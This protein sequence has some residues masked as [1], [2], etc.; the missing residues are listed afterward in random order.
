MQ[1]FNK[2]PGN[3]ESQ[4]GGGLKPFPGAMSFGKVDEQ[5]PTSGGIGFASIHANEAAPTVRKAVHAS[6]FPLS[7]TVSLKGGGVI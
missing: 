1:G 6:R 7:R 2:K 3:S 5:L 4:G